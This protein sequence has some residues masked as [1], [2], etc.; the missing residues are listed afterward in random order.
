MEKNCIVIYG[1][2]F[3]PPLNSHFSIA[4]QVLNQFEEVDKIIFVPVNSKYAKNGL[5]DNNHRY[6]MLKLISNKNNRFIIS[7][8]DLHGEKSLSTIEALEE[9]Q[10]QFPNKEVWFVIGSDNLKEIHTWKRAEELISK[11]KILVMERNE[12]H[13]EKIIQRNSLLSCYKESFKKLNQDIKSNYNSTYVRTQIKK[14]K[15]VRYLMPDEIYEY[16]QQ[17]KLYME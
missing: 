10:K 15:S 8:I 12:D 14:G 5:I 6:N 13:I 4:E 3:N 7:D 16:I 17:N 11:Y 9:I 2:S 1:G